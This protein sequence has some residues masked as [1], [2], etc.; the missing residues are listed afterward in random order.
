MKQGL[1]TFPAAIVFCLISSA[2]H[3]AQPSVPTRSSRGFSY[4]QIEVPEKPWSIHVI[5]IDR[6]NPDLELHSTL[7]KGTAIGL[8]TLTEQVK[9]WPLTLGRPVA[10]I[11]GDYYYDDRPYEGDPKGLQ[12]LRGEL[13]SA[14]SDWTCTWF[15]ASGTPHMTN[16][17][18]RLE[19]RWPNSQSTPIGLN[20]ARLNDTAVLFT[21]AIGPS[22]KTR[23]GREFILQP[24][25]T[26]DWLPLKP[27]HS[28][29]A[30]VSEIRESGNTP[31]SPGTMIVSVGRQL[32]PQLPKIS[33]GHVVQISTVTLP[34]LAGA[35]T[36]IGGGPALIRAS[37]LIDRI[38]NRVRHPRSAIGWNKNEIILMQVDGRQLRHSVGMTDLELAQYMKTL[39]CDE[40]MSLD[41]GGSAACWVHG[42]IMN[43]PSEGKERPMANALVLIQK[44]KP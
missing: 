13:I 44:P 28:Y 24:A 37:Q 16:V 38:D 4:Q 29:S 12:I 32:L 36:A 9:S 20:E 18:T 43:T 21:S 3:G 42:Q 17:T 8:S 11:N 39:G 6:S 34:S 7:G 33:P 30:R 25:G 31:V 5:R 2:L 40:A 19:V 1:L 14:P 41:G 22:T 23:G 35:R 10:A 27:N 15:D 26:N